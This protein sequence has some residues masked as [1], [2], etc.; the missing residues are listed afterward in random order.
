MVSETLKNQILN[1]ENRLE[2]I[3]TCTYRAKG[4]QIRARVEWT[5]N[6]EKN[7]KYFLG[8]EKSQQMKK[9]IQNLTT[10]DGRTPNQTRDILQEEVNFYK[11]LYSS[12][13][14]TT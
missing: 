12:K 3:Y 11:N 10:S 1:I 13:I 6:G 4:A 7:S 9:N 8:L 14:L 5:E 2:D